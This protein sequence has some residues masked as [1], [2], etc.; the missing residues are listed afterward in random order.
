MPN[1]CMAPSD[2]R[3][4]FDKKLITGL[5]GAGDWRPTGYATMQV[6]HSLQD[7]HRLLMK[8]LRPC[9][10]PKKLLWDTKLPHSP[11]LETF[12]GVICPSCSKK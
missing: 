1:V 6:Q 11:R 4:S 2:V 5:P 10:I 8:K 12:K 7:G 9:R 3:H